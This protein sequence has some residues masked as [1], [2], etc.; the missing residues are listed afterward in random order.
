VQLDPV[1][2]AFRL[3]VEDLR[4]DRE[5]KPS[6]TTN[7]REIIPVL[8]FAVGVLCAGLAWINYSDAWVELFGLFKDQ[9]TVQ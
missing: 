1:D 3:L 6:Q 9:H 7:F 2:E 4:R 8:L 5:A